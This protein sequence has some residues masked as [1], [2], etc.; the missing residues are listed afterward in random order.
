MG[1]M[2]DVLLGLTDAVEDVKDYLVLASESHTGLAEMLSQQR[3]QPDMR[4]VALASLPG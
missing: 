4:P 3:L 2:P 1:W